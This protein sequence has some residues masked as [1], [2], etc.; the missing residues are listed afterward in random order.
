MDGG[1]T[2]LTT[3]QRAAELMEVLT[4]QREAGVSEL[5]RR[6]DLP[7]STVHDYLTTLEAAG[8]VVNEDGTY[9]LGLRLLELGSRA[10]YRNRLFHIAVPELERMVDRTGEM[11][12]VNVEEQ[13]RFVVL[14]VA[15]GEESLRLGT[16]PGLTTPLHTHAAGK[17]ML[18][19]FPEEKTERILD[20]PLERMT[21][22][23]TT[24]RATLLDELETIR[25]R[26]YGVDWDEQIVGMGV[27]AAPVRGEQ[28]IV[29]SLGLV[30]PTNRLT[31]DEYRKELTREVQK[32]A[33]LVSVNHQFH[34]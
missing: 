15:H 17:V 34:P 22:Y 31:D 11:M 9:T 8:Y 10:K 27:V 23:T 7:K 1:A 30:C 32:S 20:G 33:N 25:D 29:G 12:S 3:I 13:G 4:E 24:D 21:E 6:M 2:R 26:G 5:A 19:G 18:A 14:H 16:Y 28:G